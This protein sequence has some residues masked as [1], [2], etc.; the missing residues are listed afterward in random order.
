[1]SY[2][3]ISI[4][5]FFIILISCL[6]GGKAAYEE[7]IRRENDY[8]YISP[9]EITPEER[10]KEIK[11]LSKAI[12]YRP[13]IEW[14]RFDRGRHYQHLEKYRAAIKDY[15]F[16]IKK[17][18]TS[19]NLYKCKAECEFELKQYWQSFCDFKKAEELIKK[20]WEAAPEWIKMPGCFNNGYPMDNYLQSLY[21]IEAKANEAL[22][23][24]ER[25]K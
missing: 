23:A 3:L 10:C 6:Q 14:L 16:C 21:E 24:S 5:V 1:M 8:F 18:W 4:F 9:F 22:R 12:R 13:D 17:N 11:L 7:L 15:N 25:K 19:G 20:E 2:R